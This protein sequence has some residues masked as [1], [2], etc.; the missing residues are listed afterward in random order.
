MKKTT[1]KAKTKSG[2]R[3]AMPPI[4]GGV[5]CFTHD[6]SAGEKRAQARRLGGQ[7]TRPDH[8]SD[9]AGVPIVRRIEPAPTLAPVVLVPS[10]RQ[11]TDEARAVL[12]ATMTIAEVAEQ[13][14][15]AGHVL[16][17]LSGLWPAD[18][19]ATVDLLHE[20]TRLAVMTASGEV[21]ARLRAQ[22]HHAWLSGAGPTV[23]VALEAGDAAAREAV[24]A[25]AGETGMVALVLDVDRS[26]AISC[27]DG[28]CA[29]SGSGGCARCPRESV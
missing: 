14:A 21:I 25:I 4:T 19:A 2:Q 27:P 29:L 9:G 23:A 3:C 8:G 26:G 6:P 24:I 16:G 12:P 5:Y 11:S 10:G 17:A 13:S 15:R 20:P 1:C 28:G 22:G 18:V 7:R